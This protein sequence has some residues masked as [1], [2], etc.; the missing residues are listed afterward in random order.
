METITIHYG[1]FNALL[2]LG[3]MS[4]SNYDHLSAIPL[5]EIVEKPKVVERLLLTI[6]RRHNAHGI[7]LR[8]I[9][10]E[11]EKILRR[12]F[13]D[14]G[15]GSLVSFIS[16]KHQLFHLDEKENLRCSETAKN[17]YLDL[18]DTN[19][20]EGCIVPENYFKTGTENNLIRQKNDP[21]FCPKP[22]NPRKK[23]NASPIVIE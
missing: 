18:R 14:L 6:I 15:V 5:S 9:A 19:P 2:V 20:D 1:D 21:K 10:E 4:L 3:V 11:F 17:I 8:Q 22:L 13:E 7:N 23:G 16:T 12:P